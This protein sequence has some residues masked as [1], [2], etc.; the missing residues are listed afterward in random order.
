NGDGLQV[1]GNTYVGDCVEATIAALGAPRGEVY[2]VGGGETASVWDVLARLEAILGVK[3]PVRREPARPA[4][5]RVTGADTSRP[6]AHRSADSRVSPCRLASRRPSGPTTSGP[7]TKP[8][9]LWT[10]YLS[11]FLART[12]QTIEPPRK[13]GVD[14]PAPS[15]RL[16][17]PRA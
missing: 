10:N 11:Y 5:Q 2:N 9:A 12:W 6:P 17:L 4:D 13:A 7:W 1:R 3:A 8:G 14:P 16:A 15:S